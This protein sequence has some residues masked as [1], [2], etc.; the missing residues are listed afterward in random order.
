M[1]DRLIANAKKPSETEKKHPSVTEK[2]EILGNILNDLM[3][4]DTITL[5][6]LPT[7]RLYLQK[8]LLLLSKT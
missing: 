8:E 5:H 6:K 3:T 2:N 7:I 1:K 4:K